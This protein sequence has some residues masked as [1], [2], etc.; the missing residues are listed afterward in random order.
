MKAWKLPV[1]T[2]LSKV[3]EWCL[4]ERASDRLLCSA[5]TMADN[6]TLGK[7]SVE[8]IVTSLFGTRLIEKK[9]V[10]RWPG[11]TLKLDKS[12]VFLVDFDSSL[13][14]PMARLGRRIEDWRH[15]HEP[16]LPEDLCLFQQGDEWP[17]LVSVTHER[18]AW[19]ISKERPHFCLKAPTD[20][21]PDELM[22]PPP[23]QG[24]VGD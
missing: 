14:K 19:I 8:N 7:P 16:P 13:I 4:Q 24:F 20:L 2:P 11:T 21:K 22:I 5:T 18:E 17:V 10:R 12:M 3:F 1:R 9:L 15:V 6:Q 23:E